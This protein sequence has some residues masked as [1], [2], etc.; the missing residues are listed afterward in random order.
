MFLLENKHDNSP[1]YVY[2]FVYD[3]IRMYKCGSKPKY[4]NKKN[5]ARLK[6]TCVIRSCLCKI[7][8]FCVFICSK[9]IKSLLTV[10]LFGL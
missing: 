6:L 1:I 3:Y 2:M 7:M 5:T 10:V 8:H 9:I 4:V